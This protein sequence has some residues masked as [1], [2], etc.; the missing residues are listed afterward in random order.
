MICR[1]LN[2]LE[3]TVF[4]RL[5]LENATST[6]RDTARFFGDQISWLYYLKPVFAKHKTLWMMI[7]LTV[8][9]ESKCL[10]V[11]R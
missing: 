3:V 4:I 11:S 8:A 10:R 5:L 1:E 6:K 7:K 2:K 9:T